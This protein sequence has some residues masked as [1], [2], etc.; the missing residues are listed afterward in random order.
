[1]MLTGALLAPSAGFAQVACTREGLQRA[2]DLYIAAQTKGDTSGLPLAMVRREDGTQTLIAG[3]MENATNA[4]INKGV[5][6]TAMKID[7]HRSLI[8]RSTCQ[9]FT[10]V[11]V[12]DKGKPYVL[13]TR[14]RVNRDKIAEIEILWTT[15]GYWLFNADTY[16]KWSSSEKWDVIPANRRDTRDT[17]VAAA[18]AYLDA[19][20]EGKKDGVPWGYPCQR[21]EG[22]MHTGK[23]LPEDS[24]DVGVPSGVNIANRR[25][26]VD[27]TIGSVVVFCTFGAGNANGGSGAPD[28]HLFRVEN[29]K[30]RYV[31]TLTHLMQT[32]FRGGGAG[33]A[34]GGAGG[35]GDAPAGGAPPAGAPPNTQK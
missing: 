7:H 20:L 35:R 32:N 14:I 19:F 12:T 11:I 9:T 4:D 24:C 10:E 15:T 30:L 13:G 1:M 16:L 34:G 3:Y 6:K 27:P 23:G 29:G 21:T 22:G 26:I 5:I 17:L 28:T 25:F 33:R 8:D 31:H 2:I 18:N